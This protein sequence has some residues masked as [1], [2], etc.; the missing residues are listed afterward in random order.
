M[1]PQFSFRFSVPLLS[2]EWGPRVGPALNLA[3]E[4][5]RLGNS[6]DMRARSETAPKPNRKFRLEA[7]RVLSHAK[8]RRM[9]VL[10]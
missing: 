10:T 1:D 3:N 7:L 6:I 4:R 8:V 5:E 2:N 9:D